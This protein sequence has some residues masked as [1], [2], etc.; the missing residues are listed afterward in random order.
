MAPKFNVV[1]KPNDWIKEERDTTLTETQ[2]LHLKFWMQFREYLEDRPSPVRTIK[3]SKNQWSNVAVG[4]AGFSLI[5]WNGMRDNRSGV[6]LQFT[7]PDAKAC[8]RLVEERHRGLIEE[9]LSALG[10]LGWRLMPDARESQIHLEM[11][12]A[13]PSQPETWPKLNEWMAGTLETMHALFSPI[14]RNLI[15]A[16]YS[17]E[18]EGSSVSGDPVDAELL[19]Y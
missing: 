3:P 5:P 15:A 13:T 8:F 9:R 18:D 6:Y 17:P 16:E 7:G 11:R 19:T 2:R 10:T 4:R 14:V 1:S 12:N